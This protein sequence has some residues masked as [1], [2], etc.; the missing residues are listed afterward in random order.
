MAFKVEL[1]EPA[2]ADLDY[3]VCWYEKKKRELAE[4][5]SS[6]VDKSIQK[7]IEN[8]SHFGFFKDDYRRILLPTFPYKIVF[9]VE[10]N[11]VIIIA[12]FH[13]SRNENE[14]YNR[15]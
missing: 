12:I 3:A 10:N 15:L 11:V 1:L 2:H 9:K 14:I 6:E 7:I 5:F 4:R 8:P 13:T